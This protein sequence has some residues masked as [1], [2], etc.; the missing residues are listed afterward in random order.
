MC[1]V[2]KKENTKNVAKLAKAKIHKQ[3]QKHKNKLPRNAKKKVAEIATRENRNK[4]VALLKKRG[5]LK[6]KTK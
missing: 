6:K 2:T 1:R 4:N 5:W 3:K